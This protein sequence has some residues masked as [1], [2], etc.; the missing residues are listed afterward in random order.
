MMLGGA[1]SAAAA[2]ARR[3]G[4]ASPRH[5]AHQSDGGK[6]ALDQL[7]HQAWLLQKWPKRRPMEK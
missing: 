4:M 3:R 5:R 7:S 1:G 2:Q 6:T